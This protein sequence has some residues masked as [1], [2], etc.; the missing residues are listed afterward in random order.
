MQVKGGGMSRRMSEL[1][2]YLHRVDFQSSIEIYNS[3]YNSYHLQNKV[4]VIKVIQVIS[5]ERQIR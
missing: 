2:Q 3:Y 1:L 5:F 4:S